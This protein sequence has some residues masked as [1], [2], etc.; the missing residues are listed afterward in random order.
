MP[1]TVT[2]TDNQKCDLGPCPRKHM[3]KLKKEY[4]AAIARKDHGGYEEEW[5]RSLIEFISD[6]DRKIEQ[7]RKRLEK[8]PEDLKVAQL[9]KEIDDLANEISVLT[10]QV[11]KL[12]E[13]GNVDES[14][15]S[16]RQVDTLNATKLDKERELKAMIGAD[17]SQHQK[18][19]MH[20][21][22]KMIRDK[23]EELQKLGFGTGRIRHNDHRNDGPT[24]GYGRGGPGGDRG[25]GGTDPR[26]RDYPRGDRGGDYRGGH[27]GGGGYGGNREFR[28][29]RGYDR[30]I[31]QSIATSLNPL[32]SS[33]M[34]AI[35]RSNAV[36][37]ALRPRLAVPALVSQKRVLFSRWLISLAQGVG[38]DV[39]GSFNKV[40]LI[41]K[42]TKA[43]EF[44]AFG[45]QE[46]AEGPVRGIWSFTLL[47]TK[48]NYKK[49]GEKVKV[50]CW[51]NIKHYD[52]Q[53]AKF[54]SSSFIKKGAVVAV[55]GELIYKKI[56]EKN[57]T[58]ASIRAD[59]K[60]ALRII[61]FAKDTET[62]SGETEA[63]EKQ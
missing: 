25:G 43:P 2:Y 53:E 41:G 19:R 27:G 55:E 39:G 42:V 8:T 31:H 40:T 46:N 21:G 63:A 15:E 11:E 18:L 54:Y 38:Y 28:G 45:S 50:P 33:N 47:T 9:S 61:N 57:I 30:E 5:A 44:K 22:F 24:G 13:E 12:G 59:G 16:M 51:H 17:N 35:F 58:Y 6:C 32:V 20:L 10:G 23:L 34:H 1:D 14:I 60:N 29:N 56:E 37:A 3:E 36:A 48:V 49:D 52:H 26:D 62:E 4:E 7:A